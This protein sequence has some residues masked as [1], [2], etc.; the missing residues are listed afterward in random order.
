MQ[1]HEVALT[2]QRL[3]LDILQ[4][5]LPPNHSDIG[6]TYREIA[7]ILFEK[8]DYEESMVNYEK[9]LAILTYFLPSTHPEIATTHKGIGDVLCKQAEFEKAL[10]SYEKA[11][12]IL[13]HS[14]LPVT[15][16]N[17]VEIK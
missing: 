9:S 5:H 12:A 17:C 7:S 4:K 16:P 6:I 13:Q 2:N 11:Q 15:H 1:Q 14:D 8:A 3:A 10:S